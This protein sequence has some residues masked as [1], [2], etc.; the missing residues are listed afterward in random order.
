[1][2]PDTKFFKQIKSELEGNFGV[3]LEVQY[4]LANQ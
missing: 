3:P 2:P 4:N 1:M